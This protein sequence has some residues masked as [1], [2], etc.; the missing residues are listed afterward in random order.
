MNYHHMNRHPIAAGQRILLCDSIASDA[1]KHLYW[2]THGEW[3]EYDAP[4]EQIWTPLTKEHE[5][6]IVVKF[7]KRFSEEPWVPHKGATIIHQDY[8][9]GYV[10][11]Y[12]RERYPDV[13][14]AGI[15]IC[16]DGYLGMGLGTEALRLWVDYLFANSTA[17]KIALDTWSLNH[18]MIRVAEKTGFV[19]EG[20]ERH[21]IQWQG[22]W[23]DGIHFGML[24]QEWEERL[25]KR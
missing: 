2:A 11:R 18:R 5:D 19:R 13:L 16:E 14:W 23:L 4:W 9:V 8:P 21:L 3:R 10:T 24:R 25:A 7:M 12:G 15:D 20:M 1:A 6:Q 22:Q 17:H